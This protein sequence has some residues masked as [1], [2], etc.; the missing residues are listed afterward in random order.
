MTCPFAIQKPGPANKVWPD[1]NT[2]EGVICHSAE[3]YE[4][5]LWAQLYGPAVSWH[6]TVLKDGRIFQHYPLTAST[7][8]AGSHGQNARLIGIEHEGVAGEPLTPV[9]LASSVG[10]VRWLAG[11]A[12]WGRLERGK[13]LFE[14]HEVN[15]STNCPS[16][17]IPWDK[18]TMEVPLQ[19]VVNKDAFEAINEVNL[20][21]TAA[22]AQQDGQY[23]G[24]VSGPATTSIDVHGG[25]K[26]I[27]FVV[28]EQ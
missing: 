12:Q 20:S 24:V 22:A 10:L 15:P 28:K 6:F 23:I 7:W 4:A 25:M 8:H 2:V 27:V 17:R 1:V 9:Q 18:Y 13:N 19:K 26:A 14:H 11:V 21:A 5:G 3:G 16:G